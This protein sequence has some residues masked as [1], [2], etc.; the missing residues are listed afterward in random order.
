MIP[1]SFSQD[2]YE[3]RIYFPGPATV[4]GNQVIRLETSGNQAERLLPFHIRDGPN[5]D[6]IY[7]P[8]IP[9]LG[10]QRRSDL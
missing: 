10:R 4:L 8:N 6:L 9:E 7:A 3:P 1:G 5:I 2:P